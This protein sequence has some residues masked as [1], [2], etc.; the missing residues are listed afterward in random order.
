MG[1]INFN[2]DEDWFAIELTAG[3]IV[4]IGSGDLDANLTLRDEFGFF[5]EFASRDFNAGENV[6]IT[7]VDENGTFYVEVGSFT[8]TFLD[9]TL[10]AT[11][12]QDDFSDDTS[13]TGVL[14]VGGTATGTIDFRDDSDW[15]AIE[16]T[17]GEIVRIA[18]DGSFDTN[19]ILRDEAENFITFGD[20]DFN[21]NEAFLLAEVEESGTFYV[22]VEGF[23]S[24][25]D[26]TLTATLIEDDFTNDTSTTGVLEVGGTATGTIDFFDDSDWFAIELT[27]GETTLITTDLFDSNLNLRDEFGNI[28]AFGE[29]DF[30]TNE[31]F[32]MVQV[33]AVSYTHLTLPT[34]PYV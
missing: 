13:T 2:G 23:T 32:L 4:R 8:S 31:T 27:A 5:V 14:T 3:E 28:V 18:S 22:E 1:T 19:L 29:I 9:Y 17:A 10:T 21:T 33:E 11:V 15:F 16:L 20:I 7:Q 26:Y 12:T 24:T 6:L 34:T 30:N 25:L